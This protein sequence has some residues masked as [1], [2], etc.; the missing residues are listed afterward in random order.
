M[1]ATAD[2]A[3]G[4]V[5]F[6]GLKARAL[7]DLWAFLVAHPTRP[8]LAANEA[9][10]KTLLTAVAASQPKIDET[11]TLDKLAVQIPQG[12]VAIDSAKF[13]VSAAGGA[14]GAFGEHFEA[15]GLTLPPTLI[16]AAYS[17]FAPTAL[18]FG[19]R[20]S[21][22][23]VA[24]AAAEAI[25]DLHLAGDGP[26]ISGD[27]AAKARAK[28][29]GPAGI[30]I[31]IE[32]S[33]VVAPLIDISFEGR[34]VYKGAK[35]TGAMTVRMK[36]FDKTMAAL[37]TLG[38]EVEKKAAPMLA[39]AKGL[40]KTDGDVAAMGRRNRRRRR[41]EGQ[42]PAARQ[43]AA[44][45]RR[46]RRVAQRFKRRGQRGV[47]AQRDADDEV[48][49]GE[50]EAENAHR[51][52]VAARRLGGL[53]LLEHVGDVERLGHHAGAGGRPFPPMIFDA[54]VVAGERR[55]GQEA[56]RQHDEAKPGEAVRVALAPPA[57]S[58]PPAARRRRT[59][60]RS[61]RHS[62]HGR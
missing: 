56:E 5:K 12:Q 43:G 24:G 1:T 29:I 35:P 38:P 47:G 28:L 11:A 57:R 14:T 18:M 49:A 23:D 61:V 22:L 55:V 41:D 21:G 60:M 32:P 6:D 3:G 27:D 37:K 2:R 20:A 58:A 36:N 52:I 59:R 25:A 45:R 48:P 4:D 54:E 7:L 62:S 10:F 50:R 44:I 46:A 15:S 30:V 13:G 26:P 34:I 39:M 33:H 19:F 16:P 31:D 51:R 53:D 40:A 42:R 9:A 17:G 8:E